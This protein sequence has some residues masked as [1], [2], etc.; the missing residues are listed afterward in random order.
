MGNGLQDGETAVR[1]FQ[2]VLETP[3]GLRTL[4]CR[5]DEYVWDAAARAGVALPAICHQ[6]RCLTCAGR[7]LAGSVDQS[8]AAS[9]FEQD[10]AAGFVLLCRARPLCNL[11]IRTDEQWMMREHRIANHLPAPYA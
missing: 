10:K 3:H 5:T 4:D 7:L 6:G 2:I 9:Y 8:D 1:S 11:R